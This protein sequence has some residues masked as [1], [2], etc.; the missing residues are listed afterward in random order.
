MLDLSAAFDTVNH[1]ILAEELDKIGIRGDALKW[2][3]SYLE[4]RY[5]RVE[6]NKTSS[7]KVPLAQSVPQGS[8]L[9]PVLFLLYIRDLVNIFKRYQIGHQ[10][11]AD[12]S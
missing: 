7:E 1:Q 12:D 2:I 4:N 5:Y 11:F 3:K 10:Q 9:G 8:V 6:I